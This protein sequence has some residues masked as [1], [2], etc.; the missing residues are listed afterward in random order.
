VVLAEDRRRARLEASLADHR[1]RRLRHGRRSGLRV[2]PR[3]P[4]A[5]VR[6]ALRGGRSSRTG[7][8]ARRACRSG[9]RRRG[10]LL[11]RPRHRYADNAYDHGGA[12]HLVFASLP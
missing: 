12:A 10:A 3:D 8:S 11:V 9:S 7:R 5:S 6:V 4:E 2:K 1:L